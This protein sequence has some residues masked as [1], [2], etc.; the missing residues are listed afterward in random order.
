MCGNFVL[1]AE[2]YFVVYRLYVFIIS[3]ASLPPVGLCLLAAVNN[4]LR[5]VDVQIAVLVSAVNSSGYI[6]RSGIS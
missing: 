2:S 3:S 5:N 6:F 1:L 4:T